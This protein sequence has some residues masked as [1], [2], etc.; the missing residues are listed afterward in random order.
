M[1]IDVDVGITWTRMLDGKGNGFSPLV[2]HS[3]P[4]S[5]FPLTSGCSSR[6]AS[7]RSKG[8]RLEVRDCLR[9]VASCLEKLLL[10]R[11]LL[12][13]FPLL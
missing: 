8:R 7:M 2:A 4:A 3:Y 10:A 9:S 6:R 13:S 5:S 11:Y 12:S 1:P